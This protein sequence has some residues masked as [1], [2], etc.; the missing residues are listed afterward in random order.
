M[1]MSQVLDRMTLADYPD[2]GRVEQVADVCG[3]SKWTVYR[4]IEAGQLQAV[5]LGRRL[6]VTRW[7]LEEF[8]KFTGGDG[9][10]ECA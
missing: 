4:L 8:L 3:C 7:A 6:R 9:D 1:T 5:R 2:V 10:R